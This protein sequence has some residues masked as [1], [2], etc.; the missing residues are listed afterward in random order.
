MII[1]IDGYKWH[2]SGL[3]V[4]WTRQDVLDYVEADRASILRQAKQVTQKPSRDRLDLVD[5]QPL[6]IVTELNNLKARVNE[7]EKKQGGVP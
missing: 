3:P 4:E 1:E 7:L 6:D 5:T 2:L